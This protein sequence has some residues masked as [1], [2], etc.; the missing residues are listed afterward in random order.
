MTAQRYTSK[1]ALERME[2]GLCP[3]CGRQVMEHTGWGSPAG[4]SL[5]ENGVK[6]RI[7]QYRRDREGE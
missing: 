2:K 5:T 7:E 4:C 6:G 1:I 3:E